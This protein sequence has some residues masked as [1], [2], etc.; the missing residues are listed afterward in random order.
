MALSL[1]T[2][3]LRIFGLLMALIGVT[4]IYILKAFHKI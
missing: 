2:Q 1:P 3:P 4:A